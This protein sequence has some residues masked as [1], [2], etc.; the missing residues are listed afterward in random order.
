[1][2]VEE[3]CPG[4]FQPR[5]DFEEAPLATLAE[6]IKR[7]GLMQPVIV[8]RAAPGLM[9]AKDRRL[10]CDQASRYLESLTPEQRAK[11]KYELIAGERRW[12][13]AKLAGVARV[14]AIVRELTDEEA[15]EWAV[16]ENVQRE[17]L[18]A[19]ERA[20]AY[21]MMSERFGLNQEQI[22][23]RVG[24][25]RSTVANFMRLT[26]L[27]APIRAAIGQGLLSP[28]HGKALL[29]IEDSKTRVMI[30]KDAVDLKYSV[31]RLEQIVGSIVDRPPMTREQQLAL[32]REEMLNPGRV[33]RAA[34]EK[35]MSDHLGTRV[36]IKMNGKGTKGKVTI[37]FYS[38]DQFDGML[39]RMG[40]KE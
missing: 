5:Q 21:R 39:M 16:V 27:E 35:R 30:A 1:L 20:W 15:A 40:M 6:S 29:A 38:L 36:Q 3:L 28:G 9:K 13:A 32:Q 12:R 34:M 17:D 10:A 37:E 18:N 8:R 7:T 11:V 26:E 33:A 14:P 25:D 31:R 2:G 4:S 23:D 22:A 19:M 24:Q